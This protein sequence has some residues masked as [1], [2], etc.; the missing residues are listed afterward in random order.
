VSTPTLWGPSGASW[1]PCSGFVGRFL[2]LA[3]KD[4]CVLEGYGA[5]CGT[6]APVAAVGTVINV[7]RNRST[8]LDALS[9]FRVPSVMVIAAGASERASLRQDPIKCDRS[10]AASKFKIGRV[11]PGAS[12]QR[13][14]TLSVVWYFLYS[15]PDA[16]MSLSMSA[17]F[18][19][20]R[21]I[22]PFEEHRRIK[23]APYAKQAC[24]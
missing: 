9:R 4:E 15:V 19:L 23:T 5:A 14:Q 6:A 8:M 16:L 17:G 7:V 3:R 18:T 11:R 10:G 24:Q 12:S 20:P 1:A 21:V 13:L 2:A 22:S